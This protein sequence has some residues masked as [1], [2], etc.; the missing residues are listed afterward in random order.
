MYWLSARAGT[1]YVI[2]N[3]REPHL[4]KVG[5]T[6]KSAEQRVRELRTTGVPGASADGAPYLLPL[7][8][9]R[10]GGGPGRP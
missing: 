6:N 4:V 10:E 3:E 1:V 7:S 9:D 5:R 8:F 2:F